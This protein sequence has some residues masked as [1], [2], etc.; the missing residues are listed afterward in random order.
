MENF[1]DY[2]YAYNECV[3]IAFQSLLI[4]LAIALV[5][6]IIVFIAFAVAWVSSVTETVNFI[7]EHF[8]SIRYLI[9]NYDKYFRDTANNTAIINELKCQKSTKDS[10]RK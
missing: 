9:K 6:G 3:G 8:Y 10:G 1:I 5:V 4:V 7:D 2:L